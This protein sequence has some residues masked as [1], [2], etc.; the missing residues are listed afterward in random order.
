MAF[1]EENMAMTSVKHLSLKPSKPRSWRQVEG[2]MPSEEKLLDAM[3]RL[4]GALQA[5][6]GC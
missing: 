3:Q 6:D 5:C 4:N 1:P 2:E